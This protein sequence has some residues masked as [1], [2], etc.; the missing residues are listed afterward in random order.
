MKSA[1]LRAAWYRFG[2]SWHRQ[3]TAYVAL[4][5]LIGLVGGIAMGS[6][7]GA[8]R[9]AS[10]FSTYLASTNPSQLMIEPAGGGPVGQTM[11]P[12]QLIAAIERYPHVKHVEAYAALNASLLGAGRRITTAFNGSI[13]VVGSVDG[14]LLDQD[15]I[16]ITRG[17]LPDPNDSHGIVVS[18]TAA[19]V[20]GLHLG[21]IVHLG[22]SASSG[23]GPTRRLA[24]KV[25]GVGLLNREV[26]QDQIARF[27][28]YIVATPALTRMVSDS[29]TN[30]YFGVQLHGGSN[31]VPE[32]ERRWT[33][34]ERY[35]TDFQ[36]ASQVLGEAQQSIRPIALALGVFGGIAA[37]AALLLA[38]QAIA[39]QLHE[40]DEDLAVLR[41]IG[42][43]PATTTLDGL[44]G[45]TGSIVVGSV[46]AV[47][48]AS[49]LS[50]IAPI[51]PV[52]QVYPG[53]GVDLDWTVLGSG[54]VALVVVLNSSAALI[55]F[56]DGPHRT[57][58]ARSGVTRR[59]GAV[60]LA[61]RAGIRP[62]AVVGMRF[63]L[64]PGRGRTAVPTRWALLGAV[65][66]VCVV[67][68]TLTFGNSLQAL[69]SRP[70]LYGWNWDYAVQSSDGY[71]PVPNKAVASLASD[72][73]VSET[74]GVWFATLQ[75]D[76]VEVP[77]LLAD[78]GAKVAPPVLAGHGLDASNQVVL[79]AGTLAQL[80]SHVGDEVEV[81]YVPGFP[82]PPLRLRVVGVAT[83]PA[84]GIA[85][86]LHT[87]MGIGAV[88]AADADSVTEMLGPHA[89]PGCNGPNMVFLRIRKGSS[90]PEARTAA[91]R[92]ALVANQI[93]AEAPNSGPCGGNVATALGVQRP[94]QIVNYRSMGETPVLL[95][96]G[97]AV[98]A[99][100]ALGLTLI[101]SIR[102]R[103]RDIAILKTLG[104]TKRQVAVTVSWQALVPAILGVVAGIPLGIALGRWL[105]D[106][107]A[108][109]IGAVPIPAVP[110]WSMVVAGVSAI[111]LAN[112]VAFFPGRN[113][114]NTQPAPVLRDQ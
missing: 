42:A 34:S 95:S 67:A 79:G 93:L 70:S 86:G 30:L 19:Q 35:F 89:Y 62:P 99:T 51:G 50:A 66:A 80:N 98:G 69:V 44:I 39:R 38:I 97:L 5:V 55:S 45:I 103:R 61:G 105:W 63:A 104:F 59:V 102:R 26:V 85:E 11:G 87:S 74:S 64:D 72:R 8:R 92:L 106:L 12:G 57:E 10:S 111:V 1:A 27:P 71:G 32:V 56:F 22:F 112:V 60:E 114:A 25:V 49:A 52:R 2:L 24:L 6:I 110:V 17:R 109:E 73:T 33:T 78:P 76:G 36:E 7:A 82:A 65:L 23:P 9:T 91:H 41:A 13:L 20:L 108:R 43:S 58:R 83:M 37:L 81:Q 94:A 107:F 90:L 14:L 15:R 31:F 48:V 68:A 75:L 4:V 101:S 77:T 46:L 29:E 84:I 40:R 28:T 88:V 47:A 96:A 21:Q 53:A 18:Q 100:A 16:A 3:R 113:A 54:V